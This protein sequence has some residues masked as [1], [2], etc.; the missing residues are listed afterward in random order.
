MSDK[1]PLPPISP[2][3]EPYAEEQSK[4]WGKNLNIVSPRKVV[5]PADMVLLD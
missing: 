5:G 4:E 2:Q 1:A 3:W